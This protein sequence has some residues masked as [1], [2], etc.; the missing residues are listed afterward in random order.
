MVWTAFWRQT[1]SGAIHMVGPA[2][3][4]SFLDYGPRVLEHRV[5]E[6][7]KWG[8]PERIADLGLFGEMERPSLAVDGDGGLHLVYTFYSKL[9]VFP[10]P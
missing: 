8:V 7:G 10:E 6:K 9:E 2:R 5:F 4:S 3:T 1:Q